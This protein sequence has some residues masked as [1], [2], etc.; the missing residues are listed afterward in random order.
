MRSAM[1]AASLFNRHIL[2][3]YSLACGF[4]TVSRQAYWQMI[5]VMY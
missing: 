5:D 2:L 4:E 1:G 3:M